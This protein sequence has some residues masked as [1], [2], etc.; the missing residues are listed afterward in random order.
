MGRVQTA[1]FKLLR[2]FKV[3]NPCVL[4][5]LHTIIGQLVCAGCEQPRMVLEA[6]KQLVQRCKDNVACCIKLL[7]K[8]GIR[9][10]TAQRMEELVCGLL[11]LLRTGVVFQGHVL[12][13][14]DP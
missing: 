10:L 12:L 6:G 8:R 11:F 9:L 4:P 3:A 7:C 13:L 5:V 14:A 1:L 2:S